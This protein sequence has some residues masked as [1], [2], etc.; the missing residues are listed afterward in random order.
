VTAAAT[1]EPDEQDTIGPTQMQSTWGALLQNIELMPQKQDFS[2]QPP[3]RLEA[4]AQ[5]TDD[6]NGNCN[7]SAIMF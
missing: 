1:I 7:H 2:L 6:K 5:H 4:V 3:S